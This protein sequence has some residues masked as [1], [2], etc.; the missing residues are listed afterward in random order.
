MLLGG[1][2]VA[3]TTYLSPEEAEAVNPPAFDA[4]V[5][6][7]ESFPEIAALIEEEATD[8]TELAPAVAAD[9]AAA[10]ETFGTDIGSGR[11]GFAVTASGTV[12]SVDE[13]FMVVEVP[14]L[15]A[16]SVVRVPLGAAL[17][18][19]PVRDV[20]GTIAFGDF[21]SQTAYQSVANAF[22]LTMQSDVLGPADPPSLQGQEVTVV[23]A[24]VSG[25]PVD[26]FLIQPVSIEAGQ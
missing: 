3:D 16:G 18:G 21:P 19:T 5:Y 9:P 23:G 6:A 11:Y 4:T 22:T 20:T 24:Y 26:S 7:A 17:S 15:E 1:A 10:A 14:E 13:D 8:I 2:M 12:A 25:G